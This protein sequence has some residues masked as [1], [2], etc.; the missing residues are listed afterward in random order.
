MPDALTLRISVPYF[1]SAVSVTGRSCSAV[2]CPIMLA[3]TS[4]AATEAITIPMI[5]NFFKDKP[6]PFTLV[7]SIIH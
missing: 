3:P 7:N 6:L 4:T 1:T 5:M 2:F